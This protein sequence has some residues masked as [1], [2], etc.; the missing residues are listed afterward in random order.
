ME[1]AKFHIHTWGCQ[2]NDHDT[3]KMSGLLIDS[4]LSPVNAFE[5]AD[6][7]LL[8]T[9]S[10]REKAADKVFSELGRLREVKAGRPNRRMLIGV[11]GC[12]AQ[13]EKEIIFK[14]A[15]FVDFVL[16]TM[17]IKQLPKLVADALSGAPNGI[18]VAAYP[19]N[20]LFPADKIHR[21]PTAKAL[22]TIIEG[23]DHSCTYCVVPNTR[24]G[25]RHR[26]VEDILKEIRG[27]VADGYCEIELL[28]QNVNSY[29]G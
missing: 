5:D 24:G 18:D 8:N 29:K 17:A 22:V 27:L 6:L 21:A 15:P 7:V 20:H 14:R 23:C 13:Q 3:E 2:M 10:I 26:P 25:E 4:G 11:A 28:G 1:S 12:L 16:G 9:C 19:D